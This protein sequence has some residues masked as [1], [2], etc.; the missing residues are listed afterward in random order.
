MLPGIISLIVFVC[1]SILCNSQNLSCS[2]CLFFGGEFEVFEKD[3]LSKNTRPVKNITGIQ[4]QAAVLMA[5]REIND[6]NDGIY[7]DLLPNTHIMFA[8]SYSVSSSYYFTYFGLQRIGINYFEAVPHSAGWFNIGPDGDTAMKRVT[9]LLSGVDIPIMGFNAATTDLSNADFPHFTRI[10][11]VEDL[12]GALLVDIITHYFNWQRVVLFASSDSFGQGLLSTFKSFATTNNINILASYSFHS[13]KS[14][15][16]IY[17]DQATVLGPFIFVLLTNARD[18][19]VILEQ[20]Y[21]YGLFREGTQVIG[22]RQ[23]ASSAVWQ[24]MSASAD[25][26]S[27]MKGFMALV[28]VAPL[29][30]EAGQAFVKRWRAQPPTV[31]MAA[32]GTQI[33][34]NDSDYHIGTEPHYLYRIG[35]V[36]L[37]LNFSSYHKNGSDID[38]FVPYVYDAVYAAAYAIHNLIYKKKL[39][40]FTSED[41]LSS[42]LHNVSFQ[43]LT[44]SVSFDPGT[45]VQGFQ[46]GDGERL[47]G[48]IYSIYNF[49][50]SF[51]IGK[52]N[53]TGFVEVLRFTTS[54]NDVIASPCPGCQSILYNTNDNSIP[55][56]RASETII[57]LSESLKYLLFSLSIIGYIIITVL[58]TI[59]LLYR[60][61]RIIK[62]AHPSMLLLI[63][64][65]GYM[66]CNNNVLSAFEVSD[67]ICI[68]KDWFSHLCYGFGFSALLVKTWMVSKV[69][70]SGLKKVKVSIRDG[71]KNITILMLILIVLLSILT[72]VDHPHAATRVT[73]DVHKPLRYYFCSES[74]VVVLPILL[75]I[76][77][78]CLALGLKLCWDIR[79]VP[80]ALNESKYIQAGE[81]C[82]YF[83]MAVP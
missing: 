81:Y 24:A 70:N 37:G 15:F 26:P 33:C 72:V 20:G 11:P 1:G 74:N 75:V 60:K 42:L 17:F 31:S 39:S 34:H 52:R 61:N 44:G 6:K 55:K 69:F 58:V 80:D 50:K 45:E 21:R 43:G 59:V 25:I 5:I 79:K 16:S 56:D 19:G 7:D 76:E 66:G 22:T 38:K 23:A 67:N 36:C 48:N 40:Q 3:L 78:L 73:S 53:S 12:D 30:T 9:T 27:I 35:D 71:L 13:G 49:Q 14:D 2:T 51:Y 77:V 4:H 47:T 63:L 41:L 83:L 32:D 62:T 29:D 46:I 68:M 54:K 10:C 65:G 28:P 8:T 18:T 57:S 82:S 64:F